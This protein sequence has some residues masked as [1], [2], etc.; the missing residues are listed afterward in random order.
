M[1]RSREV[2]RRNVYAS[3]AP[4][5]RARRER[6]ADSLTENALHCL[7]LAMM[8]GTVRRPGKIAS[9]DVG[10][11]AAA[12]E[13]EILRYFPDDRELP[14]DRAERW[15]RGECELSA[16]IEEVA[17]NQLKFW[18]LTIQE[19]LAAWAIAR[20]TDWW[21]EFEGHLDDPQWDK[22]VDL[23]SGCVF[24]VGGRDRVDEL[25]EKL[26]VRGEGKGLLIEAR[27][28]VHVG[29]V[30]EAMSAYEYREERALVRRQEALA[31][32]VMAICTVEGAT[33]VPEAT[34]SA[35]AEVIGRWGDPRLA[36]GAGERRLTPEGIE[37][38]LLVV[39]G[40]AVRLGKFLVTVE[41]FARFV[42]AGG[43][44]VCEYWID[45]DYSLIRSRD[46]WDGPRSW[47]EQL[48][49]P[50][51]PVVWV[52]WF[53]AM[54]Y[55][56]WLSAQ[57]SHFRFRVPTETEWTIAASPDGRPFP[58]GHE[59]PDNER[60]N[61]GKGSEGRAP[62]G[63][64]P[65]GNGEFGHCDLVGN[66]WEWVTDDTGSC[67]HVCGGSYMQASSGI[68]VHSRGAGVGPE[69]RRRLRGFRVAAERS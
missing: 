16:L 63:I 30:L 60:A 53:E 35:A 68:G 65:A 28:L 52:S 34:R 46:V 27:T 43:Y 67:P 41:E 51:K 40:T 15:L 58:W 32:R 50:N 55:C 26:L 9:I 31:E 2:Q 5:E 44:S 66:V 24:E 18:H 29:R 56:R 45:E 48:R 12:I 42:D 39:P 36:E 3:E 19:F 59:V 62:V 37:V 22:A 11:A 20:R 33:K 54:A 7:A 64:Y 25:I 21:R 13:G 8:E 38:N 10:D 49:S 17:G 69:R 1:L 57:S 14:R 4:R 61:Y 6:E 47:N 23:F